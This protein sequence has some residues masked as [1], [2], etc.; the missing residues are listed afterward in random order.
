VG[1]LL[2]STFTFFRLVFRLFIS[3]LNIGNGE[4]HTNTKNISVHAKQYNF[5]N[6][7]LIAK[8]PYESDLI[9]TGDVLDLYERSEEQARH[10]LSITHTSQ[11]PSSLNA[12]KN[13]GSAGASATASFSYL[14][15]SASFCERTTS[16]IGTEQVLVLVP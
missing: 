14:S 16:A 13:S 3:I 1:R 4:H 9:V 10:L 15:S 5:F 8:F 11:M 6:L 12:F 2:L 7:R